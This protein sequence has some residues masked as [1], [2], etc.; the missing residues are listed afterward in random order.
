MAWFRFLLLLACSTSAG[1][2][3]SQDTQLLRQLGAGW[4][5]QRAASAWPT[6]HAQAS[7][8]PVDER[9]RFP[10]CKDLRFSLTGGERPGDSGTLAAQCLAPAKW[11]LYL[12][13]QLRLTGPALVARHNL[14]SRAAISSADLETREI[15]Y[16]ASPAAYLSD[17][18]LPP[19]ARVNRPIDAGQAVRADWIIRP[20]VI[21][22]GQAVRVVVEGAGF[23]VNQEGTA[24]GSA[25]AGERVRVKTRS[26]RYVQGVAQEDG[27]VLIRP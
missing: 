25:T 1:A 9:L 18:R 23:T 6:L 11:S 19:G 14:P 17:S 27:S 7:T 26:G 20:R 4:L 22:P 2:A 15:E 8:G 3:P 10:A 21:G 13:Y 24:Q 12:S 16:S 5:E